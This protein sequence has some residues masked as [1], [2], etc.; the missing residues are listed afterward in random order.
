MF[1]NTTHHHTHLL[2]TSGNTWAC[3]DGLLYLMREDEEGG[4]KKGDFLGACFLRLLRT[5]KLFTCENHHRWFSPASDDTIKCFCLPEPS[6]IT[7]T[8]FISFIDSQY[9]YISIHFIPICQIPRDPSS[10]YH[11]ISGVCHVLCSIE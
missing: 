10:V 9:S 3:A 2:L 11:L 8:P 5:Q 6:W 7:S 1:C 4:T